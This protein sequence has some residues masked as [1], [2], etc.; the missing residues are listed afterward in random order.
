MMFLGQLE[1]KVLEIVGWEEDVVEENNE[2]DRQGIE[3]I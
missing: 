1:A 3:Y 2:Q